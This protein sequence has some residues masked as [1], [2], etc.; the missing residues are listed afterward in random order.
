MTRIFNVLCFGLCTIGLTA[1]NGNDD[2]DGAANTAT[3]ELR[4]D[5]S[6][7]DLSYCPAT[8]ADGVVTNAVASDAAAS[9][10]PCATLPNPNGCA[11]LVI[12][13][14]TAT[15]STCEVCA[16]ADGTELSR[17]CGGKDAVVDCEVVEIPD[18]DCVVCAYVNGTVIFSSCQPQD[19]CD[20][21]L[22]PA[23]ARVCPDGQVA[24]RDPNDCCGVIC[25][26]QAC[27]MAGVA[28]PEIACAPGYA[29]TVD[30]SGDCCGHCVAT[31]CVSDE[32]CPT[33]T[34]CSTSDGVCNGCAAAANSGACDAACHGTCVWDD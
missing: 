1:C 33:S 28:C 4:Q 9:T 29:L 17:T 11:T 18:P 32:E 14:D 5:A 2:G 26:P 12:T 8:G 3:V 7:G 22:C 15:G 27:D 21:V 13:V 24:A 20:N 25:K 23:I 19:S 31:T 30:E 16:A 10:L 6:S 34:H